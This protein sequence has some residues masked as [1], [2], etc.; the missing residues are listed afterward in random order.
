MRATVFPAGW[1][2]R[3][4]LQPPPHLS[5]SSIGTFQQCPLRFK[6]SRIDGMS[7]PPT[8]ATLRGNFVHSVFEA[9]YMSPPESRTVNHARALSRMAW[10]DEYKERAVALLRN[11][12]TALR[13]FR[14]TSW[15]CIE[16]LFTMEDPSLS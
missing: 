9:L 11:D 6:F 1:T 16:N 15:W 13:E 3:I 8:E 4:V 14:W 7:E 5:P 10:E 12:E 2:G